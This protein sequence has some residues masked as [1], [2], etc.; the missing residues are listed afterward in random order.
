[1]FAKSSRMGLGSLVVVM[2]AMALGG[3]AESV[4]NE[5]AS[6]PFG[7]RNAVTHARLSPPR[8]STE[9]LPEGKVET[10]ASR[11]DIKHAATKSASVSATVR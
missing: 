4:A 9:S 10:F 7:N 1:M 8:S 5:R 6:S 3:C 2:L 11:S